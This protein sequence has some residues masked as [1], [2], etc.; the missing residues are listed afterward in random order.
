MKSRLVWDCYVHVPNV[1]RKGI[2]EIF[3]VCGSRP[4]ATVAVNLDV[5]GT[6]DKEESGDESVC[7]VEQTN[8]NT[9]DRVHRQVALVV[10]CFVGYR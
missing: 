7:H 3:G 4:A 10:D 1:L 8:P 2:A 9:L 5:V 6:Q